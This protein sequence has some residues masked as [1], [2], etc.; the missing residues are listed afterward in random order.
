M[1]FEV[2]EVP[3]NPRSLVPTLESPQELRL[4]GPPGP[5]GVL[6]KVEEPCLRVTLQ[7]QRE[8]AGHDHLV[9]PGDRGSQR[10]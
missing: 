4:W 6:G 1:L 7:G 3:G 9:G 2:V 8:P 5:D 10:I